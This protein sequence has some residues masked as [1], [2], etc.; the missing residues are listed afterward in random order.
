MPGYNAVTADLTVNVT[1][2]QK[3]EKGD[4]GSQG[5]GHSSQRK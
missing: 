2:K 3:L 4:L 1:F 5:E